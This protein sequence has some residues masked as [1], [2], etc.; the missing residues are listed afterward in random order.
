MLR[1][2]TFRPSRVKPAVTIAKVKGIDF[3]LRS[4]HLADPEHPKA[5][6]IAPVNEKDLVDSLLR[7]GL[8]KN[9]KE[10]KWPSAQSSLFGTI[11]K[12]I[13]RKR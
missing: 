3:Q 11:R 6:F 8:I 7:R 12:W 9:R 1:K 2:G 13:S 5:I 10:F 4:R